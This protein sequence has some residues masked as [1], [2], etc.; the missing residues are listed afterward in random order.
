MGIGTGFAIY[1][2]IWWMMIFITLPF[3]VRSQRE[4]GEVTPGTEGA[5]PADPQLGKRLLWNSIL[6]AIVFAIYWLMFYQFGF[7][8]N[9]M[10]DL[11]G[12]E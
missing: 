1:F 8:I 11:L 7:S 3:G 10:P 9:D 5:A 2:L 12:V 4:V 6:S